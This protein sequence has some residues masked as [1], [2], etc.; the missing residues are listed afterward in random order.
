MKA[1]NYY[2]EGFKISAGSIKMVIGI[3]LVYLVT[4]LLVAIPFYSAF[5]A[6]AGS[7][8]LPEGLMKGFDATVIREILASGGKTFIVFTRGLLPWIIAFLLL[9]IY[10][11]GGIFSRISH[12][13]G[14]YSFLAFHRSGTRNYWR[15]FKLVFWLLLIQILIGLV[16]YLPY[17]LIIG[18]KE[19]LTDK[20]LMDPLLVIIVIHLITLVLIRLVADLAK[21]RMFERDSGKA[22][23]A[24]WFSVKLA[25]RRF[26]SVY[27]MGI[28]LMVLPAAAF[29]GFYLLRSAVPAGNMTM[30]LVIGLIQQLFILLRIFFHVWR[31]S[32]SYKFY[33]GS[34]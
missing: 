6:A 31:L 24:I 30:V 28:L 34:I 13:R 26:P 2:L 9:Q 21:S 14:R 16:L 10:F 25:F 20:Q 3:Y 7:S 23:K 19:G 12:P 18:A 11:T 1:I 29:A 33:L 17:F 8:L 5:R 4:G 22:L 27:L 15:F 32:S